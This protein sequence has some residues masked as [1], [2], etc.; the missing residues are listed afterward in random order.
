ML[1][2]VKKL[3]FL[4]QLHIQLNQVNLVKYQ[5]NL[6]F[7]LTHLLIERVNMLTYSSV[8]KVKKKLTF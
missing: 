6:T 4:E 5:Y 3:P 1:C 8:S 7:S 2:K